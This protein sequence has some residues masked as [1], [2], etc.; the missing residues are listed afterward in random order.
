MIMPDPDGDGANFQSTAGPFVASIGDKGWELVRRASRA[1]NLEARHP[2][3]LVNVYV[4][5]PN[6]A[7]TFDPETKAKRLRAGAWYRSTADSPARYL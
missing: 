7:A 5:E 3:E 4:I 6:A 1:A 2:G